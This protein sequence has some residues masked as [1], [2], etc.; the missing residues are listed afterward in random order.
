MKRLLLALSL[1]IV[2][3][4][5]ALAQTAVQTIPGDS[6]PIRFDRAGNASV[7]VGRLSN[8]GTAPTPTL[9]GTTGFSVVGNDFAG[10]VTVGTTPTTTCTVTFATPYVV[11]PVCLLN[12]Q[13]GNLAAMSWATTASVLTITQ[14]STASTVINYLCFARQ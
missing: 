6:G 2:W 13:S 7:S 12:W 14:T 1:P 10:T 4:T 5:L 11:A 8:L 9:C 3:V